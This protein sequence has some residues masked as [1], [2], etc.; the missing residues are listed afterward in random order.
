MPVV[1][2]WYCKEKQGN[3]DQHYAH[4]RLRMA[5]SFVDPNQPPIT[6]KSVG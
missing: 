6:Q 5:L 4:N 1:V 2:G 3:S